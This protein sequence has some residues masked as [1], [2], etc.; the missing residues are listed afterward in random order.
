MTSSVIIS[1]DPPLKGQGYLLKWV[2]MWQGWQK[3]YFI[4]QDSVLT[5]KELADDPKTKCTIDLLDADIHMSA[6]D[7]LKISIKNAGTDLKLRA[8]SVSEKV[9]WIDW[10][11]QAQMA[12]K[13]PA[14]IK[15]APPPLPP[16]IVQP[17]NPFGVA[18]KKDGSEELSEIDS[19]TQEMSTVL[20]KRFK[21]QDNEVSSKL[22]KIYTI[23]SCMEEALATFVK[24][25]Q[26][27]AGN[28][29]VMALAE[30][31]E[32]LSNDLKTVT[33]DALR[34]TRRKN[35]EKLSI[36]KKLAAKKNPDSIEETKGEALGEN[37][38]ESCSSS[39]SSCT[40]SDGAF[41]TA[42]EEE[43]SKNTS[44]SGDH[45]NEYRL[46][47]PAKRSN[48]QKVSVWQ[49]LKD[50]V[51][52]DLTHFSVPIYFMEPITMLQKVAEFLEYENLLKKAA[53]QTDSLLRLAYVVAFFIAQYACTLNRT[54]KP[55]N[56]ILGETF[57]YVT[58]DF[59][60]FSEQV[61]HHPPISAC[62]CHSDLYELWMHTN[63]K[64]TFWGKNLEGTPLGSLNILLKKYNERYVISRPV[65]A[66]CNIIIGQMYIDNHGDSNTINLKTGEKAKIHFSK[67]GWFGKNYGAVNGTIHDAKDNP[68]YEIKG[69]W[70]EG[71]SL[72]NLKTGEETVIWRINPRPPEWE[73]YYYFT[74][75]TYQLNN[76]PERLKKI[77]PPTDSRFRPDSK[78]LEN[79]DL[80]L[81]QTEK[82]RLEEIQRTSRKEREKEKIE[83][84]PVYFVETVDEYTKEKT[85][86]SNW[87][88]W[89]DRDQHNWKHL[90]KLW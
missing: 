24:E 6:N 10:L 38:F 37:S 31:L 48:L 81:S 2:N 28:E 75:F 12:G 51:G 57:E 82:V 44:N 18:P 72:K 21:F 36:E 52:K 87:K 25:V 13:N 40:Y 26:A 30:K 85:Y 7:A 42:N 79:G 69:C 11:R 68:V 67:K 47:L 41:D 16:L 49:V 22:T 20:E 14:P 77:L 62:H 55:F 90:P 46:G 53:T 86:K 73:N 88:Y 8:S 84:K 23:Q 35:K 43:I 61:S 50:M 1:K 17:A 59:K 89:Q 19:K 58:H 74:E 65:S 64:F 15:A 29:K 76:L 63:M 5:Y 4:I 33:V 56:P 9:Q 83:H 66:A 27:S 34:L 45:E 70:F 80:K 39:S 32:L 60:F 78:A 71:L 54:K 3:R